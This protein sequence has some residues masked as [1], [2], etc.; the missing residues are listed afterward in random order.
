[1]VRAKLCCY[2]KTENTEE[3]YSI[4]LI[5]VT[6]RIDKNK[7]FFK[8]TPSEKFVLNTIND[9]AAERFVVGKEYYIDFTVAE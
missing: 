2:N 1:M 4:K 5:P 6:N 3:I 9:N 8:W 7:E